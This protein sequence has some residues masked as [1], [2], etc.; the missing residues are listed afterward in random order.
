M[1]REDRVQ[2]EAASSSPLHRIGTSSGAPSDSKNGLRKTAVITPQEVIVVAREIHSDDPLL[3]LTMDMK[4]LNALA[5]GENNA[6]KVP[7]P[8]CGAKLGEAP[9]ILSVSMAATYF[10]QVLALGAIRHLM[11]PGLDV[12]LL[13]LAQ[14]HG[15]PP[16][17]AC[18]THQGSNH[19]GLASSLQTSSYHPSASAPLLSHLAGHA[20]C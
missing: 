19:L 20:G 8:T 15:T 12:S 3:S 5:R 13:I 18:A 9:P 11:V 17:S 10:S 1:P 6:A 7:D 4:R 14:V 16:Q 2:T